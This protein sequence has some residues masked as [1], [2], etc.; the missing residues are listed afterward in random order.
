MFSTSVESRHCAKISIAGVIGIYAL[1]WY[2]YHVICTPSTC[3]AVLFDIVFALA[4]VSYLKAAI[5]DPGTPSSS[6]WQ[7]WLATSPKAT[8]SEPHSACDGLHDSDLGKKGWQP[9]YVD[10]C[11]HCNALRPER[12][13]HCRICGTCVLRM[14]HHC[15][16]VG[17][18]IGWRTHKYFL[19]LTWWSFWACVIWLCTIRQPTVGE[20]VQ[21]LLGRP[22]GSLTPLVGV[23]ITLVLLILTGL[24]STMSIL[25][26]AR[27]ESAI[28]DLFP[29]ENPYRHDSSLENIRQLCGPLDFKIFLPMEP[30]RSKTLNGCTYPVVSKKLD[31]SSPGYGSV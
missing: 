31:A 29:G 24:M 3:G 8:H 6:E 15:P 30:K 14:D 10:L 28:E 26:A 1:E 21:V 19:L 2:I 13:H 25:M 27:N 17:N 4:L 7:A 23:V 12:A 18:C 5:S 9:G 22:D 20:S 11:Q 16:W